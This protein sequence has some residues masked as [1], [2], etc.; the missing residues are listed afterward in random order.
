MKIDEHSSLSWKCIASFG[1]FVYTFSRV[2]S[3]PKET[4]LILTGIF[5]YAVYDTFI[6]YAIPPTAKKIILLSAFSLPLG[7]LYV[8][9]GGTADEFMF[10]VAAGMGVKAFRCG[11]EYYRYLVPLFKKGD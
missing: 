3:F 11:Y 7:L 6:D 2:D 9:F 5:S 1:F 8:C 10:S 4:L